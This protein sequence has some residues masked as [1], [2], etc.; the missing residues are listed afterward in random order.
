MY[1]EIYID[2]VFVTNLLLDYFLLRLVGM[3]FMC[4]TSR[5]RCFMAAILGALFSSLVLV[6]IEW[7]A[8]MLHGACA[9][10]MIRIGCG[11]KKYGLLVKG[12]ITMY[13]AAFLWGGFWEVLLEERSITLKTFFLSAL[14]TYLGFS[15]IIYVSDSL[16]TKRK[17]IY[18]I[19]LAFQGKIHKAYGYYDTGNLLTDPF[20]GEAV[21][22]IDQKMLKQILSKDVTEQLKNVF[23]EQGELE[24]TE[25]ACLHPRFIPFRTIGKTSGIMLVIT[26]DELCIHTPG[27]VIHISKPVLGLTQEPFAL[28]K[29]CEVLLNSRFINQEGD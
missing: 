11:L 29:E 26:L 19:T 22:V 2:L 9:M 7:M 6:G 15:A 12:M 8:F 14:G 13:L 3:L 4:R 25:F 27:E 21:S 28:G 16:R 20:S 23:E 24:S 10:W 1:E 5:L 18:P 17:H